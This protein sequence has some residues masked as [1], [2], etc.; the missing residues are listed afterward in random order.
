LA[1]AG[2][3]KENPAGTELGFCVSGESRAF[4][5]WREEKEGVDFFDEGCIL[6]LYGYRNLT[7]L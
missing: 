3:G 5:A 7:G 1:K 6:L 2:N 4:R